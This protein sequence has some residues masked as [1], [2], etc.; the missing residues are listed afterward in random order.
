MALPT[1]LTQEQIK[2]INR[3]NVINTI[4]EK[5]E[6]T[7]LEISK[8]LGL[9]LPTVT[10]NV[11]SLMEEGIIEQA[12]I[13]ES[14]GG[15]KPLVLKFVSDARFSLGVEITPE[16]IKIVLMNLDAQV[17]ERISFPYEAGKSFE[18]NL[19]LVKEGVN[20][21]ISQTG[22]QRTKVLGVGF[23]L[24]GLVD[25]ESKVLENAPNIGVRDYSFESFEKELEL[26]VFM[27]NEANAGAFAEI[28]TGHAKGKDNV[29]YISV[30]EGIGTGIMI[31]GRIYKSHH[32]KAGEFGHMR[33]SDEAL[34]CNCGRTGCWELYSSKKAMMRYVKEVTGKDMS[35]FK[36]VFSA[37]AS[38]TDHIEEAIEK[39]M[40]KLFIG[41]ENIILGLN[42]EYVII[43]GELG[44][45]EKEVY[46]VIGDE[47]RLKSSFMAYEGT[48]ISFSSLKGDGPLMGAALLPLETVF[49]YTGN[50]I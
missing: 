47:D 1:A 30:T 3:I 48:K 26:P 6:V 40:G 23:A 14:T 44:S 9:S 2:E 13:A 5:G 11:N 34:A 25:E 24:P 29:I 18:E 10:A 50:I 8:L 28:I 37:G 15:R 19:S 43:G 31:N 39:Y 38:H 35:S 41:I 33:I 27:E 46:A 32:K 22:V 21:L 16:K 12:G 4:K 45:F 49:N 42:P 7:K 17:M 20:N 36:E